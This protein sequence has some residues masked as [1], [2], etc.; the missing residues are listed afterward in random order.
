ML[1]AGKKAGWD[2]DRIMTAMKS[3]NR[4]RGDE[5]SEVGSNIID[6]VYVPGVDKRLLLDL[7]QQYVST[8]N[9]YLNTLLAEAKLTEAEPEK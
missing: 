3:V 8:Q 9:T 6:F 4:Y 2:S 1:V 5:K 7:L